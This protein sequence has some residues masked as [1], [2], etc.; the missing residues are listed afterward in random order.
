MICVDVN[1]RL[2][3]L[4]S[5][6]IHIKLLLPESI[7]RINGYAGIAMYIF[8]LDVKATSCL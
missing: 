7:A 8:L 6:M 1:C 4:Y 2:E 3:Y 5:A